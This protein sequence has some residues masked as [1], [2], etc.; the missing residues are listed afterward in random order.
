VLNPPTT[1]LA[2]VNYASPPS[3]DGINYN[4]IAEWQEYLGYK[5]QAMTVTG[6]AQCAPLAQLQQGLWKNWNWA[7]LYAPITQLFANGVDI[8]GLSNPNFSIF[9]AKLLKG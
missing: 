4:H 6:D 2:T 5:N 9:G 1:G 8:S 3:P 7:P